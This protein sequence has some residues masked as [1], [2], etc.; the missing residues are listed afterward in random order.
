LSPAGRI[1]AVDP[2]RLVAADL[3]TVSAVVVL[4]R[5]RYWRRPA[6]GLS[7]T[8]RMVATALTWLRPPHR[9]RV[10]RTA[11]G[12]PYLVDA[13][14]SRPLGLSFN[15]SH[16]AGWLMAALSATGS[17]G[18]DIQ[19]EP[20]AGWRRMERR[21]L[22]PRDCSLQDGGSGAGTDRCRTGF[23]RAWAIREARCKA[24]GLGMAGFRSAEPVGGGSAGMCGGVGWRR[25][26]APEGY[27]AAVAWDGPDPAAW[28]RGDIL[29][30]RLP[31]DAGRDLDTDMD[32]NGGGTGE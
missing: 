14:T 5:E 10:Q 28:L 27:A 3:S 18:V 31:D 20:A 17:V 26:P 12:R 11:A 6:A 8:P 30:C 16:S 24:M 9:V 4:G 21:W 13:G 7:G 25:V 29:F 19:D 1:R 15:I 23:T 32:D 22:H 2:D